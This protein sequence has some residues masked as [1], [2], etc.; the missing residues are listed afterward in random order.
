MAL[1]GTL[2]DF[3]IIELLQ[4]PYH[5]KKT[6]EMVLTS[7]KGKAVLHYE[8]GQVVHAQ[9]RDK[10][11]EQVI[12][13][14]VDWHKGSFEIGQDIHPSEKTINKDL[15]TLLLY[16]VKA[17]DE[18]LSAR[19]NGQEQVDKITGNL[20]A[21]LEAFRKSSDLATYISILNKSGQVIAR[22]QNP[23]KPQVNISELEQLVTE[24]VNIYPRDG[25]RKASYEDGSGIVSALRINGELTLMA[26]SDKNSP[27]GAVSLGLGRLAA[28]VAQRVEGDTN[29]KA[30]GS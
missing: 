17:R 9:F 19:K 5:G 21:Q 2:D 4:I 27:L 24:V 6:C 1:K 13:E 8:K 14:I 15:H 10:K 30:S 28:Q 18:R 3:G 29:G 26:V 7:D 11:G 22:A 25:F 23:E 16:V 20:E 12:E